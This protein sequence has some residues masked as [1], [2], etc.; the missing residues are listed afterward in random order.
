M[1]TLVDFILCC[2][3]VGVLLGTFVLHMECWRTTTDDVGKQ[4]VLCLFLLPFFPVVGLVQLVRMLVHKKRKCKM[5]NKDT[6][7]KEADEYVNS[8]YEL[9]RNQNGMYTQVQVKQAYIAGKKSM[10][11][12]N[13]ELKKQ[14]EKMRNCYNCECGQNEYCSIKHSDICD[15]S[16]WDNGCE[17]WRLKR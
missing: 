10:Q 17:D 7:L 13:A 15:L 9:A 11:K 3:L 12:E 5:R 16:C 1:F 4:I 14:I 2:C 8:I 6:L